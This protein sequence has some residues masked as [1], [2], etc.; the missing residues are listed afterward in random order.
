MSVT[1]AVAS[2][3]VFD[4]LLMRLVTAP[5]AVGLLLGRRL[6]DQG[7]I[8]CGAEVFAR[9][10]R[11]A[12][13]R[14]S[15]QC[16]SDPPLEL[17]HAELA[18]AL[19]LPPGTAAKMHE[20]DLALEHELLRPVPGAAELVQNARNRGERVV[21]VSDTNLR[22]AELQ[23]LLDRHGFWRPGDRCFASC[24]LGAAKHQGTLFPIVARE[25]G[26]ASALIRHYGDD[27]RSDVRHGR[28]S[29]W[30]VVHRPQASANRYESL[31]EQH[32]YE[33]GGLASVMAGASRAS[34]LSQTAVTPKEG[35]LVKVAAGVVAPT[36]SAWMLNVL[37]TAQR[38]GI[39]RLY[40]L[41]RDGEILLDVAQRLERKLATG[42]ELRYLHGSRT[43]WLPAAADEQSSLDSFNLDRDF[44]SVRTVLASIGLR[45]EDALE[46]LPEGLRDPLRWDAT[47]D[48]D[49]ASSLRA[50][51]SGLRMKQLVLE[52]GRE[53]RGRL[54]QYLRQE[55][56]DQPGS[57]ALV[58]IGWRGRI[59]RALA[60]VCDREG[61]QLPERV[62]FFGVR[63]D[64]HQVVGSRL[65][66]LL[67]GWYYDHA[68][69]TGIVRHMK[70][71]EACMEMFC[72]AEEGSVVDYD[73][74]GDRVVPVLGP[75]RTDLVDW[76]LRVVRKTVS[77]F[78]DE[79]ILV[80]DL[81]DRRAD[82]R[83]AVRSVLEAFW[84]T[85]TPDE[86]DA[87][88]AFPLTVDMFHS[89]TVRMA[90]P[91]RLKRVLESVGEGRPRLRPDMSWPTGTTLVSALPYR[92]AL[93]GRRRAVEELPRI[94]RRLRMESRAR[95][96]V[97]APR[98]RRLLGR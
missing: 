57:V 46:A 18:R 35:A 56:W 50:V 2:F 98:L 82:A 75:H 83:D 24:D 21:F 22:E 80:D 71:L 58:D 44:R 5:E 3:D 70:D 29:G 14:A 4:T 41:S 11:L 92:A 34:R 53:A 73:A 59:V 86:V 96:A 1:P 8:P 72:A 66:P 26:V 48:A 45:P 62:F 38:E 43:T 49:G 89:R 27:P 68:A 40:F 97:V 85:P 87:W 51:V 6:R 91:I 25:L 9:Q 65:A 94:K 63:H 81:V 19:M 52:H 74:T 10:R 12:K 77:S 33:T 69:S 79:L 76:G 55:E 13:L 84:L 90:E 15:Q 31:L 78:A 17:V 67:N 93:R 28:A 23:A 47:L 60:D 16:G 37:Q 64:A 88:A 7:L 36:L 39:A 95:A 20:G 54:V 30:Q 32:R 61:L 42:V